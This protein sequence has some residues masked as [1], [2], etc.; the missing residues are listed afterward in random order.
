[1]VSAKLI[2]VIETNEGEITNRIMA[3][4]HR[5]PG[6]THLRML[7]EPELRRRGNMIVK[8]LGHWLVGRNQEEMAKEFETL[9]KRRFGEDIPLH[10]VVRA[11]FIIKEKMA[12]FINEQGFNLD[13]LTLYAEEE[14]E[15][16]VDRFFD[17]LVIH[18]VR[19]YE[20]AW[21]HAHAAHAMA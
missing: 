12:D 20:S 11:L 8:N 19:G 16:H 21:H 14:L 15:R 10:E 9:G 2:Q 3:E 5:D 7:T 18:L 6:L 13:A 1:M 17:V 4:I